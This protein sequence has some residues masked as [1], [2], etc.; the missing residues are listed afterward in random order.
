MSNKV[1]AADSQ[2]DLFERLQLMDVPAANLDGW[3]RLGDSPTAA[4]TPRRISGSVDQSGN[5]VWNDWRCRARG[6][7]GQLPR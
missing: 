1:A 7:H 5:V 4:P 2:S 6:C 3:R